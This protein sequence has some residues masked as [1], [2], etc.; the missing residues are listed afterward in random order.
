[1]GSTH[2][3]DLALI[4]NDLERSGRLARITSPVDL[5][6]DLAGLA[7]TLEGG[8]RAV[9]FESVKGHEW[10]VLAGLYWSRELLADLMRREERTLPQYVADCT[11]SWQ[12]DPVDPVVVPTGP[13]LEVTEADVDL[14][15]MPIPIHAEKDGGPYFEAGVVIAK[16]P[17][18][19]V[20]N[21]SIQRFQVVAK[22]RLHVN[23]DAGRH[24]G[25]Y[26]EKAEKLGRNLTFTLNCGV[27]PG[28]HFAASAPA[29]AAPADT[30]ELGIASAFHGAPLELVRAANGH[31]DMVAHA[32][33]ALECE[34]VPGEVA[35]EGPFAEVTGYYTTVA[36]RPVV[37]VRKIHRRAN[38]VFQ[39]I[40]SG[41][42][43]WNSVGLLGEANV[44]QLLQKQVPGITDVYM[45]HGGGGF[46]H[47]VVQIAQQREGWSKQAILAAFAAFPPLKMVTVVD[48]DVNLRSAQD[49]EWAMATRMNPKKDIVT[50]DESFGHGLNPSF[51]DYLGPKVGFDATKPYPATWAYERA[52]YKPM[53]LEAVTMVQPEI[54]RP[55]VAV[56]GDQKAGVSRADVEAYE[57]ALV[58][59][60]AADLT[61][62]RAGDRPAPAAP[63]GIAGGTAGGTAG[64]GDIGRPQPIDLTPVGSATATTT[65]AATA[66]DNDPDAWIA[67]PAPI[68]LTPKQSDGTRAA[69][70][71]QDDPDAWIVRP[72]PID[73][74]PRG[75]KTASAESAAPAT[76]DPDAWIVR[77]AAIDLAPRNAIPA[78]AAAPATARAE[79]HVEDADA[80]IVRPAA[81][82]LTP[83]LKRNEETPV[84]KTETPA[85]AGSAPEDPDAWIA[86]PLAAD[87]TPVRAVK[88]TAAPA[89]EAAT[90]DVTEKAPASAAHAAKDLASAEG[91]IPAEALAPAEDLARPASAD[92]GAQA[93]TAEA[94]APVNSPTNDMVQ[95][96][97]PAEAEA[98]K[99]EE[100]ADSPFLDRPLP[101]S[102]APVSLAQARPT[103][104]A[105]PPATRPVRRMPMAPEKKDVTRSPVTGGSFFEP[106]AEPSSDSSSS[107]GGM[108]ESVEDAPQK[109]VAAPRTN[110][111]E[112]PRRIQPVG[113]PVS[114]TGEVVRPTGF[115]DSA[116]LP[117]KPVRKIARSIAKAARSPKLKSAIKP[118]KS[119]GFFSDD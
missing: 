106:A 71:H 117:S 115:F 28:L 66:V 83:V 19:G 34:I 15:R 54:T 84:E 42:E 1:M 77:P 69:V 87:L 53:T 22:D 91:L 33:W 20:R 17:E 52:T 76:E 16:D 40:L 24:L 56:A 14:G 51:P 72:A 95:P 116:P 27:G 58:R 11:R 102:P 39:T 100:A 88:V 109:M 37:H 82:D 3:H 110:R 67:R 48:D 57:A 89:P 96:A 21:A 46:Y 55:A 113:L 93:D 41:I 26:L 4:I 90:E 61:P 99:D 79:E 36:P 80:W 98:P 60:Q 13:V 114:D 10:P 86:R 103:A 63:G 12:Q 112:L 118:P 108:S 78:T 104:S 7:A 30:D 38:P 101:V 64:D 65:V 111:D 6:H 50:I 9:L 2:I 25:L 119:G 70:T 45:S 18:T 47:C 44:L 85:E 81:A 32:M 92:L 94:N 5:T 59:P 74:S 62:I 97:A 35:D 43:V 105:E 23:I 31:D 8:P 68:D 107:A 49:V 73:L 29:E 75:G